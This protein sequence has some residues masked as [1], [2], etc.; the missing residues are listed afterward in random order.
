MFNLENLP[1][2]VELQPQLSTVLNTNKYTHEGSQKVQLSS[3][4]C[5]VTRGVTDDAMAIVNTFLWYMFIKRVDLKG[6]H[7][8]EKAAF[9]PFFLLHLYET[10]RCELNC[11]NHFT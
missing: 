2:F 10:D 5:T 3:K 6:S 11:I 1:W 8:K 9:F 7:Y 4:R